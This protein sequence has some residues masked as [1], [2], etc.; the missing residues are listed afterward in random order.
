MHDDDLVLTVCVRMGIGLVWL[1]VRGPA[2]VGD[3]DAAGE[4]FVF[5]DFF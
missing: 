5:L 2:G 1:A 3:A 4:R